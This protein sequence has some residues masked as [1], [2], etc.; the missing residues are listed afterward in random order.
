MARK[1]KM[2]K[3]SQDAADALAAGMSY[4]KWKAM[5]KVPVT[6]VITETKIPD[7]WLVCKWCGKPFKPKTKRSQDY[8]E[9]YCQKAAYNEKNREKINAYQKK[10]EKKRAEASKLNQT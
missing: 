10:W 1:K 4:G 8:C 2:D 3:L 7:G 9:A 6:P 5:Q